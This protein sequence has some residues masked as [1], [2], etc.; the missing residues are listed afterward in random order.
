MGIK[1][2]SC[3]NDEFKERIDNISTKIVKAINKILGDKCSFSIKDIEISYET[4]MKFFDSEVVYLNIIDMPHI[5]FKGFLDVRKIRFKNG[6]FEQYY[7]FYNDK[8]VS[9]WAVLKNNNI[10]YADECSDNIVLFNVKNLSNLSDKQRADIAH[11]AINWLVK[12]GMIPPPSRRKS[13][14]KICSPEDRLCKI[15]YVSQFKMIEL[16]W[17]IR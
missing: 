4:K 13:E 12:D 2:K 10:V 1:M 11:L 17:E 6:E 5:R 3:S 14:E 16:N 9:I 8:C 15:K 7:S